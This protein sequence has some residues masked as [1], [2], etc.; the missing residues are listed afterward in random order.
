MIP[1][2][3]RKGGK[4]RRQEKE[5]ATRQKHSDFALPGLRLK[6]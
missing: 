3:R 6:G 4:E 2:Y 1:E 5:F